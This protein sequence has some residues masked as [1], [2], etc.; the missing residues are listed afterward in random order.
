MAKISTAEKKRVIVANCGGW[1]AASDQAI[2]LK[3]NALTDE[4][5][6]RYIENA[7]VKKED[8]KSDTK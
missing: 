3:W 4:T 2:A 1:Q 7:K 5:R 8:E 6:K